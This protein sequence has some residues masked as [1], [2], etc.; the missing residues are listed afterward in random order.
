MTLINGK[1]CSSF[2]STLAVK[3]ILNLGSIKIWIM[4]KKETSLEYKPQACV[5]TSLYFR[6]YYWQE[7]KKRCK[8]RRVCVARKTSN[9]RI[10]LAGS[11][12]IGKDSII[13]FKNKVYERSVCVNRWCLS[14]Q[15]RQDGVSLLV[16]LTV[17]RW[18]VRRML[19]ARW[20]KIASNFNANADTQ[21]DVGCSPIS[22]QKL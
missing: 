8:T 1:K 20:I 12:S 9:L 4:M 14:Y 19:W 3:V 7:I 15:T 22:C 10:N 6:R 16:C 13:T 21:S 5:P 18:V 17:T 2:L 11:S